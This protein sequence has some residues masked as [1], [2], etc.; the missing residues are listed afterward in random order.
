LV[1]ELAKSV[2]EPALERIWP[3][4]YIY[5]YRIYIHYS[6]TVRVIGSTGKPY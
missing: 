5:L 3:S 1:S 6:W 2:V 4:T